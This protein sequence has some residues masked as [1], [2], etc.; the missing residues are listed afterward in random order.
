MSTFSKLDSP[1][2]MHLEKQEIKELVLKEVESLTDKSSKTVYSMI[3][4]LLKRSSSI[5]SYY[6]VGDVSMDATSK[7]ASLINSNRSNKNATP[8]DFTSV[9]GSFNKSYTYSWIKDVVSTNIDYCLW[10]KSFVES[11]KITR[12]SKLKLKEIQMATKLICQDIVS[13]C[14]EI[15][16]AYKFNG[17]VKLTYSQALS[18]IQEQDL[19][20]PVQHLQE[21]LQVLTDRFHLLKKQK[22][23]K[24]KSLKLIFCENHEV[25]VAKVTKDIYLAVHKIFEEPPS[26]ASKPQESSNHS[27]KERDIKS[28]HRNKSF[29]SQR[30]PTS[31][32]A[33]YVDRFLQERQKQRLQKISKERDQQEQKQATILS[34][35]VSYETLVTALIE[36]NQ[37]SATKMKYLSSNMNTFQ[38]LARRKIDNELSSLA[39]ANPNILQYVSN[40]FV[41]T[42][43]DKPLSLQEVALKQIDPY[44]CPVNNLQKIFDGLSD[45][46]S[47]DS[48]TTTISKLHMYLVDLRTNIERIADNNMK[49]LEEV[50]KACDNITDP[51]ARMEAAEIVDK[52]EVAH[53]I[54]LK[55]AQS[56]LSSI[57][58]LIYALLR[59]YQLLLPLPYE[60]LDQLCYH[61][62]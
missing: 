19:K 4:D 56:E 62:L 42:S 36:E 25:I 1:M 2:R 48:E 40:G 20:K 57:Q 14:T 15:D 12:D 54:A 46:Y 39:E 50:S 59:F 16:E 35:I 7:L 22:R 53:S 61:R 24:S 52:N 27:V 49:Y 26:L 13:V 9:D 33:P 45:I 38:K 41:S 3:S 31:F 28:K 21:Q 29:T 11:S 30:K 58:K 43:T 8:R 32:S 5:S 17:T 10:Q 34:Q 44:L 55:K 47:K 60:L 51:V 6:H 18:G 23:S 37:K